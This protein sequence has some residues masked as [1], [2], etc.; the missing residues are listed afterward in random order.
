MTDRAEVLF[1]GKN[2]VL[3]P[4]YRKLRA[5]LTGRLR[6]ESYVA[7]IY[8]GFSR[9]GRM[10]AAVYPRHGDHLEI[11]LALPVDAKSPLLHD[12]RHLKWPTMQLAVAIRDDKSFMAVEPLIRRAVTG[13]EA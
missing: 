3:L 12:A 10:V 1:H 11:A 7:T 5:L 9:N 8:V 2:A 13:V 4:A 6:C